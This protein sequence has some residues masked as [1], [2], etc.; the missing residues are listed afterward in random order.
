MSISCYTSEFKRVIC[1]LSVDSECRVHFFDS[2]FPCL[3]IFSCMDDIYP[4][5]ISWMRYFFQKIFFYIFVF[6]FVFEVWFM[7]YIF[8]M[9]FYSSKWVDNPFP[10]FHH[11]HERKCCY[12]CVFIKVREKKF[13]YSFWIVSWDDLYK[14]VRVFF[15]V[16]IIDRMEKYLKSRYR[17]F[18]CLRKRSS[19]RGKRVHLSLTPLFLD[20]W[21]VLDRIQIMFRIL[22]CTY[23]KLIVGYVWEI[24]GDFV[25]LYV[26][27][28]SKYLVL[29]ISCILFWTRYKEAYLGSHFCYLK[30]KRVFVFLSFLK[31]IKHFVKRDKDEL[32]SCRT[33]FVFTADKDFV[34]DS[35]FHVWFV[36]VYTF[37]SV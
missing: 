19:D 23:E 17:M 36:G 14:S 25:Y 21:E 8:M 20:I 3:W 34:E 9:F 33:F 10:K 32:K 18:A 7:L 22:N 27:I 26:F 29:Y 37:A 11:S 16:S 13:F 30:R 35:F 15:P 2:Y 1:K 12:F 6:W 5:F 28:V 31:L 24:V 4:Y